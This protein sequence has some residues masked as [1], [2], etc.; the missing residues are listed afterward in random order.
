MSEDKLEL[1]SRNLRIIEALLFASSEPVLPADITQFL[2]DNA[3]IEKLL[4]KLTS[5]YSGRGINLVKR[6]DKFAFR[7]ADDLS[8]LLRREEEQKKPLTR[9]SLE[10][11][12][13]IAYHQPVT[14]AEIEEVR[15]V[16]TG[17]G[18]LDILMEAGWVKMRG[19]R[20][21]PG[22]PITYGTTEEFLDH[23]SLESLSD[24]PGLEELKGAGL[25]SSKLPNNMQIPMPFDGPLGIDEDPLDEEDLQNELEE[26]Q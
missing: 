6:G 5:L 8:Y 3:D 2:S 18:T 19:R 22:R 13:I 1:E 25:L 11:L 16:A 15:G 23:F 14:R 9:P 20:R 12:S 7:T 24:L 26:E 21:T 17:S 10:T 4:D